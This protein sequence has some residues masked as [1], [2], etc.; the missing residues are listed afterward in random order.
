MIDVERYRREGYLAVPFLDSSQL[1]NLRGWVDELTQW[2]EVGGQ[3]MV[4]W[5]TTSSNERR[6]SRIENFVPYHPGLA[7]LVNGPQTLALVGQLLGEPAVLFKDKINFKP[8]YGAGFDWHQDIQAGWDDYGSLQ[9]SLMLPL[10]PCTPENGCLEVA[11]GWHTRGW[12]GPRWQPLSE[13]ALAGAPRLPLLTEPGTA[14][15]FDSFLPHGSGPNRTAGAR[16]V[17]YATYAKASEGDQ[18]ERYFRDK[19]ASYPPDSEREP[20]REYV[21]KV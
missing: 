14:V 2:P 1:E 5:E 9:L 16:R 15:F 19:R 11:P 6:V 17:L 12:L 4:Y 7:E 18:R 21:Y 3:H 13:E 20:G 8:P 10:D